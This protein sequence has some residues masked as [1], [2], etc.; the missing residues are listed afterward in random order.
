MF[1]VLHT[2]V[3][4]NSGSRFNLNNPRTTASSQVKIPFQVVLLTGEYSEPGSK[5]SGEFYLLVWRPFLF[6][7]N[8][9]NFSHTFSLM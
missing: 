1:Y 7:F 2:S 9:F 3:I 4:L 5:Q 8:L 6:L